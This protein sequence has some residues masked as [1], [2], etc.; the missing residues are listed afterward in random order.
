MRR[1]LSGLPVVPATAMRPHG[2][3]AGQRLADEQVDMS[4]QE[5]ARAE[6]EDREFGQLSLPRARLSLGR[7]RLSIPTNAAG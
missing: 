5:P 6:L 2:F 3:A 4:L 7:R 1:R